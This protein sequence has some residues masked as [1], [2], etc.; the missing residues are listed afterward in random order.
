M[1]SRL[2]ALVAGLVVLA[3]LPAAASAH[4]NRPPRHVPSWWLQPQEMVLPSPGPGP[5]ATDRVHVYRF[6]NWKARKV[7][8]LVPGTSGGAGNFI[9]LARTLVSTVRG[10][11]VWAMDRRGAE[12]E[13]TF[14]FRLNDPD[15]AFSYYLKGE[16]VDGHKFT[17]VAPADAPY[18]ADWGL[19][20]A[21]DD[22]HQVIERARWSGRKVI[23]G[24]HSLGG[25]SVL[26]YASWDFNGRPG[27]KDLSGMLLID[28]GGSG[29]SAT[30]PDPAL[31]RQ[32]IE[33]SKTKPF[34]DLLGFGLPWATGVFSEL[35]AQF[36]LTA[37][38]AR[39]PLAD[40]P[41]IQALIN[42]PFP[43]TNEALAGY[44]F[45]YATGPPGLSLV[46]ASTGHLAP[47]GDPRGWVNDQITPVPRLA[48]M[49]GLEPAN[50][51]EWY[52]PVRLSIDLGAASTLTRTPLQ[53][54]LGLRAWHGAE[55]STPLEVYSTNLTRPRL[56][57]SVKSLV[58]ASRIKRATYVD[59]PNAYHLD[60]LGASPDRSVFL[61]NAIPFLRS[62]RRR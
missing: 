11:Q 61:D 28:G 54:E 32:R 2:M 33:A 4:G 62:I 35:G 10:L 15:K 26:S 29:P 18:V 48:T 42:P 13:D 60:P 53:D 38:Q 46:Y 52:F 7:L 9:P 37:P 22:L 30:P 6:G 56:I 59:D 39:S 57:D 58:A 8:V 55:I 47:S 45:N 25:S 27:Y 1:R 5:D 40:Y 31:V 16:T 34:L 36:A 43:L 41:L 21:M 3:A 50:G 12:L 44:A 14:G 20:T 19:T 49:F 51:A 17:P 23:L 24:G